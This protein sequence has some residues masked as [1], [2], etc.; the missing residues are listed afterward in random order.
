MSCATSNFKSSLIS[1]LVPVSPLHNQAV[2]IAA[3]VLVI[4][5]LPW[6]AELIRDRTDT[7]SQFLDSESQNSALKYL[8]L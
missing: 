8:E 3:I 1:T 5:W 7:Q 4:L 2:D 6:S